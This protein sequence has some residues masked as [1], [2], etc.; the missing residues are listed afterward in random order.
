[1]SELQFPINPVI[2]QEYDFPPYKYYW[3]G[4][5]WKTKGIGYNPVNDLRNEV[6]GSAREAIRRSYQEAGYNLVD[7]SFELGGTLQSSSDVL[8]HQLTGKA[9]A[10][11]E[12]F[13]K[14]VAPGTDPAAVAGFVMR[15]DAGL[16]GELSSADGA[17]EVGFKSRTQYQKNKDIRD[18]RDF[19]ASKTA[20]AE[21]NGE[22]LDAM[23]AEMI[24]DGDLCGH[25]RERYVV[26]RTANLNQQGMAL[27]GAS[28][29]G[30][31]LHLDAGSADTEVINVSAR[32]CR[33]DDMLL[34]SA[35]KVGV[36][37]GSSASSAQ[38]FKSKGL[39]TKGNSVGIKHVNGN[40]AVI[41]DFFAESDVVGYSAQAVNVGNINGCYIQ[42]RAYGC[43]TGFEILDNSTSPSNT[44]FMHNFLRW[45]AEGNTYGI[46]DRTTV[47][48]VCRYNY[49]FLYAEGNSSINFDLNSWQPNWWAISNPNNE[50]FDLA[51]KQIG[52]DTRGL[53]ISQIIGHGSQ[54]IASKAF[55]GSSSLSGFASTYVVTNTSAG[56][57]SATLSFA[58]YMPIGSTVTIWKTDNTPG[59]TP[60][61]PSGITFIGDTGTFGVYVSTGI[62]ELMVH[63]ISETQCI[64]KKYA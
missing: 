47:S 50:V 29:W 27:I 5:K 32:L 43:T 31:G 18:I 48:G 35:N 62:A 30:S 54:G 28:G 15:S 40:S 58:S 64:L 45:T 41:T 24:A 12:S 51:G 60:L 9:Y 23:L 6:A 22:A 19:G 4:V 46:R 17:K 13:P 55:T 20:S 26:D 53:S 56:T 63:K 36:L 25:I 10:W 61:A 21:V 52:V 38:V 59:I 7:G 14:V 3:D 2:G 37:L 42:A 16:R 1:M 8:L 44:A 11:A 49:G 57:V 39:I 33:V 34:T